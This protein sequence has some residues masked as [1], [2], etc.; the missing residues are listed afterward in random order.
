[1]DLVKPAMGFFHTARM[2]THLKDIDRHTGSARPLVPAF[3]GSRLSGA[4]LLVIAVVLPASI[5]CQPAPQAV[6]TYHYDNSRTGWNSKETI[7]NASNV[8]SSQFD[9]RHAVILDD[10]VDAQPLVIPG[11]ATVGDHST[12]GHDVVYVATENNTVYAIDTVTGAVLARRN[13]GAPVPTPL[14]CA[15]NGPNVGI[16]STPVIDTGSN[17]MYLITYGLED[18]VPVHRIHALDIKTLD[19]RVPPVRVVASHALRNGFNMCSIRAL[20]DSALGC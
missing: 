14:N 13:L 16:G 20:R 6:T 3:P 8:A 12:G 5:G 10:Q 15:N 9:V 11:L 18:Q 4:C 7:L 1:M 17:T 19:D 2:T